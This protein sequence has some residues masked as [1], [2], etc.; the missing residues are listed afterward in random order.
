MARVAGGLLADG[1][2][3]PRLRELALVPGLAELPAPLGGEVVRLEAGHE[4]LGVGP[5]VVRQTRGARLRCTDDQEVGQH[6]RPAHRS[7]SQVA[8]TWTGASR[9]MP[10]GAASRLGPATSKGVAGCQGNGSRFPP[11]NIPTQR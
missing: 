10:R 5:E 6:R 11:S 7:T 2:R 8:S 3:V 9:T 1:D 4:C